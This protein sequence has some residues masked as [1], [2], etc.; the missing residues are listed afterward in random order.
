VKETPMR[1]DTLTRVLAAY[2]LFVVGPTL[3][4]PAAAAVDTFTDRSVWV[5]TLGQSPDF[6]ET[7]GEFTADTSFQLAPIDLDAFSLT[8]LPPRDNLFEFHN[9]VQVAPYP[10]GATSEHGFETPHLSL[11][12]DGDSLLRVQMAFHDPIYSWGAD[13][14][15]APAPSSEVVQMQIQFEDGTQAVVTVPANS[16]DSP[17]F[18]GF[19]ADQWIS[20]VTLVG[21][22]N[23]NFSLGNRVILD[24]VSGNWAVIP[25][26][27]SSLLLGAGLAAL[28]KLRRRETSRVSAGSW[29]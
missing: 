10:S 9:S 19:L 2:V 3:S 17:A 27:A 4:D 21:I 14:R 24:D 26:P 25:E 6:T 16:D 22:A 23:G 13:Y 18:F 11:Y 8:Q 12:V 5:A 28:V 20:D 7:F 15:T 1:S 29:A